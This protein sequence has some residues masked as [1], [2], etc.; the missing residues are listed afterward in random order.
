M[1]SSDSRVDDAQARVDRLRDAANEAAKFAVGRYTTFLL[2]T[3]YLGIMVG[4]TTDEH[5]LRESGLTLPLF[6]VALPV[7]PFY[8]FIPLFYVLLHINV[9]SQYAIL[10]PMLDK[11]RAALG[12]LDS[13]E[14]EGEQ[15]GLIYPSSFG[16][17]HLRTAKTWRMHFLLW[18]S[19]VI[20]LIVLP[21]LLLCWIQRQFLPYHSVEITWLHRL[22]VLGDLLVI[23][24]YWPRR[25]NREERERE[26]QKADK[27]E[28][29][30]ERRSS[31][32]K[33]GFLRVPRICRPVW[34]FKRKIGRR[35]IYHVVR[36]GSSAMILA[37]TLAIA[38][39]PGKSED[40]SWYAM[41]VF[42]PDKDA[43]MQAL[44]AQWPKTEVATRFILSE[45]H[46]AGLKRWVLGGFDP[47]KRTLVL[48]FLDRMEP[49]LHRNLVLQEMILVEKPPPPELLAAY[50]VKDEDLEQA[51]GEHATGLNL[52]GRDLRHA[53]LRKSKLYRADFRGAN[54]TEARLSWTNL[55]KA[56]FDP[57]ER[58]DGRTTVTLL[59]GAHLGL[60]NLRG[61]VLS[62]A[63]LHGASLWRAE[64]HGA[65]LDS[66]KLRNADLEGAKLCGADLDGAELHGAILRR[67][68]LHGTIL[69]QAELHG[70]KLHEAK[71]HGAEL[72]D[73]ELYGA[74]LGRA[75][76]HGT[77]LDGAKLYGA[78]L[79]E[80]ELVGC[81]MRGAYIGGADF[82][83]ARIERCDL[84]DTTDRV[85]AEDGWTRLKER[86]KQDLEDCPEVCRIVLK[87]LEA[88][89]ERETK[90]PR[91]AKHI[92]DCLVSD[93]SEWAMYEW[94]VE[95]LEG[96]EGV[97]VDYRV[98]LA[99]S[100]S[101][102]AKAMARRA[103]R[104]PGRFPTRR[105]GTRLADGLVNAYD[106]ALVGDEACDG[107][108]QLDETTIN[109]LRKMVEESQSQ[110]Q[111]GN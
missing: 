102:V 58:D 106:K 67:A 42:W 40:P 91:A 50:K 55:F 110:D 73:A 57:Y 98:Q 68:E 27:P 72:R 61:A 100:D 25:K 83:R 20:P 97:L 45:R 60:A 81:D 35:V 12:K 34:L 96:F 2:V 33:R 109:Q 46:R 78:I 13:P 63:E 38:T 80:A 84:R 36:V 49:R 48:S 52:R 29:V 39:V 10:A 51:W 5:L 99:R 30:T 85:L 44:E 79:T 69:T 111:N 108:K 101:W 82:S 87:R 71:L 19:T 93:D 17:M 104:Y 31:W 59:T 75:E 66:A 76:L 37:F 105:R 88:A 65:R 77:T 24:L 14:E 7:V 9:I 47:D 89:A 8:M 15:R 3:V 32:A 16:H 11:L 94:R 54:L 103:Q 6:G 23:W 64:L 90:F 18:L 92:S 74:W 43:Y 70:A 22:Y 56:R 62:R 95:D 28:E 1:C 53:R 26:E 4:T 41:D 86:L 21:V 107:V